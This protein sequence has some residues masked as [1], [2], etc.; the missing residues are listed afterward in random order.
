[1]GAVGW[2]LPPVA[3]ASSTVGPE[4]YRVYIGTYTR[5]ES[6]GIYTYRFDS[7][8]GALVDGGLAAKVDHPSFLAVHP[9]LPRLYAVSEFLPGQEG[10]GV[11]AFR[12]DRATGALTLLNRQPT[13]GSAPCHLSIDRTGNWVLVANY[14]SGSVAVFPVEP[15]GRLGPA[16]DVVQHQGGSV[17]ARRQTGPHAHSI[18]LDPANR[19][20]FVADLG[21]DRI[22]AYRFDASQ[23]TLAPN[24][25]PWTATEPGAGP[26]HFAFHPNGRHA[27]VINE[28]NSSLTAFA[29]SD[30]DGS[31]RTLQTAPTLPGDYTGRSA[32]ADIH[33]SPDGRFVYGSNRG[34]DSIVLFAFD[35]EDERLTY[36]DHEPT[37]GSMPR[38]FAIDPTGAFLLAANGSSNNVVTFRIDRETGRLTPAGH[39]AGVPTPVCLKFV[40]MVRT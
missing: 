17:D 36:V 15:D 38:N 13:H 33:V 9:R 37:Q 23:G 40:P 16:T 10:G 18:T 12:I 4:Q 19:F 5:G 20:A 39:V 34:H 31:L 22:M 27:F 14:A 2:A 29:Y 21:M 35:T 6:E 3:R 28:L 8:T 11:N 26:R 30:R 32:C 24:A 25:I 7:G 1:M